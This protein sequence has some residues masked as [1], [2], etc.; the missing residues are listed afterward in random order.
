MDCS[1]SGHALSIWYSFEFE[2][3]SVNGIVAD[4]LIDDCKDRDFDAIAL[5]GGLP[6]AEHLKN[7]ETL[8]AMLLRQSE[9]KRVVQGSTSV[10]RRLPRVMYRGPQHA[11]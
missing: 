9:N 10:G 5:P 7:N 1:T 3:W 2:H 11:N 4:C 8:K 6:G